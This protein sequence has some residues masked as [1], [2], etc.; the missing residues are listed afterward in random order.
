MLL[1]PVYSCGYHLS[2]ENTL[3][4]NVVLSEARIQVLHGVD[5]KNTL[6]VMN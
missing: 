6:S 4:S 2:L 1:E 3:C 5:V